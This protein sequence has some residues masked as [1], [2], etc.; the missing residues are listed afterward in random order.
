MRTIQTMRSISFVVVSPVRLFLE[1]ARVRGAIDYARHRAGVLLDDAKT[2]VIA[3]V[4]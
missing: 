4:T 2:L 3:D 1:V